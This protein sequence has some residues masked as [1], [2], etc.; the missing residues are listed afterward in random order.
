MKT[1]IEKPPLIADSSTKGTGSKHS[2]LHTLSD[3]LSDAVIITDKQ[4]LI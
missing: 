3:S 1:D 4:L 2:F